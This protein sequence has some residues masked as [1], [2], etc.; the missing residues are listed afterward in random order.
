MIARQHRLVDKR[1]RFV[2]GEI[3]GG[4]RCYHLATHPDYAVV[5]RHRTG[6]MGVLDE[7]FGPP[8][9]YDPPPA[10]AEALHG[11]ATMGRP[12]R[13]LDLGAN[14]GLFA[15]Y[16]LSHYPGAEVTSYEPEPDNLRVLAR[17]AA[18]NVANWDIVQACALTSPGTVR[19]TPGRFGHACVSDYGVEV[20]GVDVLPILAGYDFVKLDTEGSEWPILQDERWPDATRDVAVLALEWHK[21][22]CS[23]KD[24][25]AAALASVEAAGFDTASS[26]P[27]WDHGMIW[28]WRSATRSSGL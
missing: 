1:L 6:D 16:V 5:V 18:R 8:Q 24:P 19:I 13:V 11:R 3:R 27:G 12:L 25:H 7:I 21:R 23:S 9:V 28:G 22:G 4:T 10:A 20:A 17:C 15:I 2:V 14:V 26:P